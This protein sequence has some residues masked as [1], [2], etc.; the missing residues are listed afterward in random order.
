MTLRAVGGLVSGA[1][2]VASLLVHL[3]TFVPSV[4]INMDYVW[5]LHVG[6]MA[7]FLVMF[8]GLIHVQSALRKSTPQAAMAGSR[9]DVR[10]EFNRRVWEATPLPVKVLFPLAM[11]YVLYNFFSS[12]PAGTPD[13]HDGVYVLH[14][15]GT[16][17]REITLAEYEHFRTLTVRG[18]SGHW[19]LFSAVPL[20]FYTWLWPRLR[21]AE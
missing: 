10:R 6:A 1:V 4:A 21:P 16:V 15:H 5:P 7:S 19:M 17:V 12:I 20:V 18:F 13:L 14:N 2:L 8:V 11:L 3:L 9:L